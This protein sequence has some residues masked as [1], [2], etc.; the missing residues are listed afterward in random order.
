MITY[1]EYFYIGNEKLLEKTWGKLY[2]NQKYSFFLSWCWIGTWLSSLPNNINMSFIVGYRDDLAVIVFLRGTTSKTIFCFPFIK[3]MSINTSGQSCFDNVMLE[4]NTSLSADNDDF[5]ICELIDSD[6]FNA[7]DIISLPGFIDSPKNLSLLNEDEYFIE[8]QRHSSFYV[9]LD[10]VNENEKSYFGLL[11]S[12]RR[13]QLK[14]SLQLIGMYGD[15]GIQKA[16]NLSES[17]LMYEKMLD[18]HRLSWRKRG[19]KGAFESR[20]SEDFHLKLLSKQSNQNICI[21]QISA[22]DIDVGYIYGFMSQG[23]FLYYQSGFRIFSDNKIK[24]GMSC[25]A[26]LINHLSSI[27]VKRYDFLSGG[28]RYKESLS[29]GKEYLCWVRIYRRKW[30]TDFLLHSRKVRRLKVKF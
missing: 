15:I 1:R 24:S 18:M 7:A 6:V 21:F 26:L 30:S 20:F 14:K 9:D 29:T 25:H 28:G 5:S 2:C 22:G 10:R 12:G 23:R 13:R 16:Q 17:E 3:Y 19:K 4:Y 11:S 8:E 27:G